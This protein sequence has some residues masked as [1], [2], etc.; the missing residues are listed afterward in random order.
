MSDNLHC[1]KCGA[2]DH[3][4]QHCDVVDCDQAALNTVAAAMR[5]TAMSF[6]MSKNNSRL[7]RAGELLASAIE[8]DASRIGA[9][10]LMRDDETGLK[11]HV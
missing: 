2:M 11:T 10:G 6:V 8:K 7:I 9:K 1:L 4:T 3:A 5:R